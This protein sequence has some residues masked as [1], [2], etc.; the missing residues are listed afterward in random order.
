LDNPDKEFFT[1]VMYS[2]DDTGAGGAAYPV[3]VG[4]FS[5]TKNHHGTGQ[6][7]TGLA[8]TQTDRSGPLESGERFLNPKNRNDAMLIQARLAEMGFYAA[9]VDGSF[10]KGSRA[11]LEKFQASK[12]LGGKGNWDL[13][14]QQALF[15]GSGQ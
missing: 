8:T 14:T 4:L 7:A 6:L 3:L 9:A 15:A 1:R 11:A 10:G 12:G 5:T 2:P 13:P